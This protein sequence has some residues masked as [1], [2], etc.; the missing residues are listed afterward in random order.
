MC[1]ERAS[2]KPFL[3]LDLHDYVSTAIQLINST[4]ARVTTHDKKM[5][6]AKNNDTVWGI[7]KT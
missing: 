7:L 3:Q 4:R 1:G 2:Q 6:L 5:G